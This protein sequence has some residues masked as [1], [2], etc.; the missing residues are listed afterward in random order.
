MN[1]AILEAYRDRLG[2]AQRVVNA[3]D[4]SDAD[5]TAKLSTT[6]TRV[7]VASSLLEVQSQTIVLQFSTA[8]DESPYTHREDGF[9]DVAGFGRTELDA[10]RIRDAVRR[11]INDL[12]QTYPSVASSVGWIQYSHYEGDGATTWE[13]DIQLFRANGT[14]AVIIQNAT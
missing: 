1:R 4:Q 7:R 5:S 12:A 6:D 3:L 10:T 9:L 14:I 8:S 13:Q 2:Q 11:E